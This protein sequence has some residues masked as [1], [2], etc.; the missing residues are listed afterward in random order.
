MQLH[1][2]LAVLLILFPGYAW[3]CHRKN[4]KARCKNRAH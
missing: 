2:D 4:E 1:Q 3:L